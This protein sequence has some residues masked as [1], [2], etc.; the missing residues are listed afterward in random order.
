MARIPFSASSAFRR[1]RDEIRALNP[2]L[3]R[4][5]RRSRGDYVYRK[6]GKLAS[7]R[8]TNGNR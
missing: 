2:A 7:I 3:E 4:T 5:R 8:V 1:A 6:I